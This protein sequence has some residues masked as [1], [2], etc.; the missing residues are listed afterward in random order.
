ME[1]TKYHA[2]RAVRRSLRRATKLAKAMFFV[3][4]GRIFFNS[5]MIDINI[6][7]KIELV[8]FRLRQR[9]YDSA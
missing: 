3:A 9:A 7:V 6:L 4:F 5:A 8:K 2:S 1:F